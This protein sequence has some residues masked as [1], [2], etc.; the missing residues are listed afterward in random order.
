[1]IQTIEY[2][3]AGRAFPA[4][5]AVPTAPRGAVVV[6]HGGAGLGAH[7]RALLERLHALGVAA[8]APDLFGEPLTDK[9]RAV[10]LIRGLVGASAA[11]RRSSS[12]AAARRSPSS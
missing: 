7:E 9:E 1:M 6:C 10:A 11:P 3:V 5:L 8:L 4:W 12:P 2:E